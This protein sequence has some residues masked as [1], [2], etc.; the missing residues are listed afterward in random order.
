[1][2]VPNVPGIYLINLG[3]IGELKEDKKEIFFVNKNGYK[4]FIRE[5]TGDIK[6]QLNKSGF[7]ELYYYQ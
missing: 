1:M 3:E 7:S 2:E 6:E 5:T 4:T